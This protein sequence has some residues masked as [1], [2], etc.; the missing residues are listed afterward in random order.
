MDLW[1]RIIKGKT[2]KNLHIFLFGSTFFQ[3]HSQKTSPCF[4]LWPVSN[5]KW[6]TVDINSHLFVVSQR[7][8]LQHMKVFPK[9][10]WG[11]ES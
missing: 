9:G 10:V 1:L 7:I 6:I 5:M 2:D 11:L 8:Q 4:F 3:T